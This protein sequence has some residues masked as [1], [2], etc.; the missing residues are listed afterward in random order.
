MKSPV[1]LKSQR[2]KQE[3]LDLKNNSNIITIIKEEEEN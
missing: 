3:I 1:V 2:S